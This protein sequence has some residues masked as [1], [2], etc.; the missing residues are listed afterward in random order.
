MIIRRIKLTRPS[1][2]SKIV[3][4]LSVPVVN[5]FVVRSFKFFGGS[6]DIS[7]TSELQI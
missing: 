5:H 7:L 6:T 3:F 1:E 2:S 4:L